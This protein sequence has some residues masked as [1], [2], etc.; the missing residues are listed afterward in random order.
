MIQTR[1]FDTSRA[2]LSRHTGH[3]TVALFTKL[4]TLVQYRIITSYV[5]YGSMNLVE[6]KDSDITL[7][8]RPPFMRW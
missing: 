6:E 4:S 2:R 3:E 1:L 8:C 5:F 7:S